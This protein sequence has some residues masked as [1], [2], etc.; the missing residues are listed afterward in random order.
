LNVTEPERTA[1]MLKFPPKE[2]GSPK[3]AVLLG[4]RIC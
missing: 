3:N 1:F 4:E 2:F